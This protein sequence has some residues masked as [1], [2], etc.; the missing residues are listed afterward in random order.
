MKYLLQVCAPETTLATRKCLLQIEVNGPKMLILERETKERTNLQWEIRL[1]KHKKRN[2]K[3]KE[4]KKQVPKRGD[5]TR[6]TTTGQ[7]SFEEACAFKHDPNKKGT[8]NG[9]HLLR[10]VHC[11]EIRKVTEK[12][13]MTEVLKA[14]QNLLVKARQ[15]QTA[16]CKLQERKLPRR[17]EDS[18]N[19]W[20]FPKCTEFK[21]P[22][23]SRFGD[24]CAHKH[25]AT[26]PSHRK[27]MQK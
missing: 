12:V 23:G 21:A 16:L 15:G 26:S 13:V 11:T 18:C 2:G 20:H 5:C 27:H 8:E 3:G 25:T 22:G 17:K 9:V 19:A 14:H 1:K 4:K 7:R 6:W 10:K 24:K